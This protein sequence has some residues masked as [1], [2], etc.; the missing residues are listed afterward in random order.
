[1]SRTVDQDHTI[2]WDGVIYRVD[3][4]QIAAG[5]RGARVPLELRLDGSM[6]MHWR[7]R[8]VALERCQAKPGEPL[9]KPVSKH[10]AAQERSA[11]EKAL[12]RQRFLEGRRKWQE[13]YSRLPDR[14]L[15]QAMRDSPPRA[16]ELL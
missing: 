6:W 4:K 11:Q 8:I 15:W 7:K 5:M 9:P 2:R 16:G 13:G 1:Q 12:A 10:R 3:R 14:P